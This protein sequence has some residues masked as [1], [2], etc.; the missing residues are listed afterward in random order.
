MS[1]ARLALAGAVAVAA[2]AGTGAAQAWTCYGTERLGGL[3]Y[4]IDKGGLPTVKLNG[5]SYDDCIVVNSTCT[6]PVHVPIP[7]V[8]KGS[9]PIVE[10]TC[11]FP[12]NCL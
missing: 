4:Q 2:F 12:M 10:V 1:R 5:S 6:V 3:C 11:M 7:T 8:T 9:G